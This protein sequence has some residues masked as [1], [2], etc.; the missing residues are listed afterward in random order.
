MPNEKEKGTT[1]KK[2]LFSFYEID[3]QSVEDA[4][5]AE[6]MKTIW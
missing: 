2:N 3:S 5:F 4:L 1:M 6:N